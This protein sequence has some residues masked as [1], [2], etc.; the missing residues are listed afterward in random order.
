MAVTF[1]VQIDTSAAV[2]DDRLAAKQVVLQEN[3]RREALDPPEEPLPLE[4]GTALLESYRTTIETQTLPN[5]HDSYIAQ[6]GQTKGAVLKESYKA[7]PDRVQDQ[8]DTLLEPY[9]PEP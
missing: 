9:Y 7:A 6:G 2:K 4:P 1:T 8:V 3:A 5:A